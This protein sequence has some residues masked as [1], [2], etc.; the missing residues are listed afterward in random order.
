VNHIITA[1]ANPATSP[2]IPRGIQG[3]AERTSM[4]VDARAGDLGRLRLVEERSNARSRLN[5]MSRV[6]VT[7]TGPVEV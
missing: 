7:E 2:A 4:S 1:A 6:T 3:I 5:V